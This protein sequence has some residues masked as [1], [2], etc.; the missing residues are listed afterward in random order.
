MQMYSPSGL[1]AAREHKAHTKIHKPC[2]AYVIRCALERD[3]E[4]VLTVM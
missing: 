3:G 4:V 1:P 2:V